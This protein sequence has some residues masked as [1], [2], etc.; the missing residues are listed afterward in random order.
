MPVRGRP[1]AHLLRSCREAAGLTQEELAVR[2]GLSARAIGNLERG[3]AQP[4]TDSLR[5]IV[6]ALGARG[7]D[8]AELVEAA[9]VPQ[10]G[11][12]APEAPGEWTA[13]P[14]VPARLADAEALLLFEVL[15]GVD[16]A[17]WEPDVRLVLLRAWSGSPEAVRLAGVVLAALPELPVDELARRLEVL[18]AAN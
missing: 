16:P 9:R 3:R 18:Q 8:G 10:P 15:T 11:P 13:G 1:F 12:W 5:R 7:R 6:E 2:S 4:R 17:D 14:A